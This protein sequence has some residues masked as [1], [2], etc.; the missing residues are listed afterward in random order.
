MNCWMERAVEHAGRRGYRVTDLSGD[1][2]TS[3]NFFRAVEEEAPAAVLIGSHGDRD[4]IVGQWDE[5]FLKACTND[6][7]LSDK[8]GYYLACRTGEKLGASTRDKGA[9]MVAAYTSD[10]LFHFDPGYAESPELDPVAWN[11]GEP[12]IEPCLAILD[13]EDADGVYRRTMGKFEEVMNRLRPDP[14][15]DTA[16]VLSALEHDRRAFIVYGEKGV[17]LQAPPVSVGE[18]VAKAAIAGESL[19]LLWAV[20]R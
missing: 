1:E 18:V 14:S 6:D 15:P 19:L 7:A 2:A 5:V 17:A 20:L 11:F 10:F 16:M 4:L 12:A 3:E 13:G 9:R 8:V